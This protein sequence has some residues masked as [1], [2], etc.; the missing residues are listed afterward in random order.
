MKKIRPIYDWTY[1]IV[2]FT[3]KLLL[4]GDIVITAWSVA[5]RYLPFISAPHW[6]EEMVLTLMVYMAVL[7]ATLAIR[8]KAHIRMT[9]FDKYLSKKAIKIS[10]ILADIA[11][12][13]LGIVLIVSGISL[14]SSPLA[15]LGTYASITGLSKFWQF[16]SIPVAG[17]GMVIFELEQVFLHM[18]LI[19]EDKKEEGGIA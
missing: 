12:M 8:K 17:L 9:S 14:C 6:G 18:G 10:D 19:E 11:V 7:S 4:I 2:L 16:L 5:G 13:I 15:S 3:C 1:K